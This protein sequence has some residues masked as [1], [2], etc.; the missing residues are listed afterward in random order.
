M[1][2]KLQQKNRDLI[3]KRNFFVAPKTSISL[4]R[5]HHLD[6]LDGLDPPS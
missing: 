3:E 6:L 1:K 5:L 2:I 4:D